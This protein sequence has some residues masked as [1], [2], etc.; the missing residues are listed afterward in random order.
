MLLNN[1]Y[2]KLTFYDKAKLIENYSFRL[3]ENVLKNFSYLMFFV[4]K[5]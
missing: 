4:E 2:S 5:Y 1:E 3:L